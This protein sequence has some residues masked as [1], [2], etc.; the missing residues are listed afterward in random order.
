MQIHNP[1]V[2]EILKELEKIEEKVESIC[3]EE[4]LSYIQY[5]FEEKMEINSLKDKLEGIKI[6]QEEEI[7]FLINGIDGINS[8][9]TENAIN[10]RITKLKKSN[11]ALKEILG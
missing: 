10:E 7:E 3:E 8:I 2:Q 6:A 4:G 9:L 5:T 1:K 11:E